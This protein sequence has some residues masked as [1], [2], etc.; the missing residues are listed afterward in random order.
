MEIL[1]FAGIFREAS[2]FPMYF[3][4]AIFEGAEALTF[5]LRVPA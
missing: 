2:D 3:T 5:T 4:R 1:G